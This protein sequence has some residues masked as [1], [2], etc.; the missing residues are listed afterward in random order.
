MHPSICCTFGITVPTSIAGR[1]TFGCAA[2][3]LNKYRMM[4]F[5]YHFITKVQRSCVQ[6]VVVLVTVQK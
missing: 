4:Y 3:L 1:T 2:E 5:H 6:V